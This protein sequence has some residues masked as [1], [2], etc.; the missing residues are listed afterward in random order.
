MFALALFSCY[1]S[2]SHNKFFSVL[3]QSSYCFCSCSFNMI[4]S[5]FKI[6]KISFVSFWNRCG[7]N[8]S[9]LMSFLRLFSYHFQCHFFFGS[10][11]K[12]FFASPCLIGLPFQKPY[13]ILASPSIT[14]FFTASSSCISTFSNLLILP[15]LSPVACAIISLSSFSLDCKFLLTRHLA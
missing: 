12:F 14:A 2:F 4:F 15:L 3:I 7:C 1:D 9:F 5:F 8:P 11:Q 6:F 13:E 10:I